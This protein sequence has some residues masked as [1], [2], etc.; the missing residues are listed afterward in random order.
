MFEIWHNIN[1]H[2][3][4]N[5]TTNQEVLAT[6]LPKMV[7]A[8]AE[9]TSESQAAEYGLLPMPCGSTTSKPQKRAMTRLKTKSQR[10]KRK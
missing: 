6:S 2:P 10:T 7:S 9:K 1:P 8:G 4:P 5:P 3:T